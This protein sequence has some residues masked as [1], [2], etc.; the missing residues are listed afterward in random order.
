MLEAG[1][2]TA[3]RA[4]VADILVCV[5]GPEVLPQSLKVTKLLRDAGFPTEVFL[6]K[7]KL[8]DQLKYADK[9]GFPFAIIIGSEEAANGMAQVKDLRLQEQAVVAQ[10]DLTNHIAV[11]LAM[12]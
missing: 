10:D 9:K 11:R 5:M 7:K 2:V 3:D 12:A 8:G 1:I 6:D 4:T